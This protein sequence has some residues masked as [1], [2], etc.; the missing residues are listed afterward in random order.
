[1]PWEAAMGMPL[2][3]KLTGDFS[4]IEAFGSRIAKA[5]SNASMKGLARAIGNEALFQIQVGFQKRADPYNLAWEPKRIPDGKAPLS[6]KTGKLRMGW[7]LVYAGPDAVIVGNRRRYAAFQSGTGVYGPT[8][9]PIKSRGG[10]ALSFKSGNR[11]FAFRSVRG[12]PPRLMVPRK[13]ELPFT[14]N[15]AIAAAA[16]EYM[17]A[18][19]KGR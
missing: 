17:R 8:G 14:W 11:R 1:M 19:L 9:Q 5:G 15:R 6:G 7:Y 13:G 10:K 12:A 18:R 2:S 4:A 3:G 16:R